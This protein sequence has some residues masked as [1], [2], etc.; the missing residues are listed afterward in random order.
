MASSVVGT[1]SSGKPA[2]EGRGHEPCQIADDAA[3]HGDDQRPPIGRQVH[4]QIEQ[5]A[6]ERQRFLFFPRG[7]HKLRGLPAG[8][9]Q[10]LCDLLGVGRHVLIGDDQG[11]CALAALPGKRPQAAQ[12]AMGDGDV[13]AAWPQIDTQASGFMVKM[14]CRPGWVTR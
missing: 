14:L 8:F 6:A 12:I 10:G 2:G 7:R 4:E 1:M 9:A 13:V 3:A 5:S 11:P